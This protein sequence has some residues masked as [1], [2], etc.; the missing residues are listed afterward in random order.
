MPAKNSKKNT[1]DRF[2][3]REKNMEIITQPFFGL[4]VF[5]AA[6]IL[7][8]IINER[9]LK[10]LNKEEKARLIDNFST[11]RIF[12]S[13]AV[14]VVL[15]LLIVSE[16]FLRQL[17]SEYQLAFPLAVISVLFSLNFIGYKKL[18][19]L[20]LPRRYLNFYLISIFVQYFGIF[21]LFAPI[22]IE[23]F[24]KFGN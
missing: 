15:G 21:F 1:C 18:T 8:R 3:R 11:Y 17:P 20:D 4:A 14:I 10:I 2:R 16:R 13:I 12:S 22:F 7:S 5:A 23:T 19:T 24:S 9:G 6:Y